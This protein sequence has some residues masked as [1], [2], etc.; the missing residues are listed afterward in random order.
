[1]QKMLFH[2]TGLNGQIEVYENRIV[3]RR[4]GAIAKLSQG[5]FK[6]DKEILLSKISAIQVK[7]GTIITNG[8]IQFSLSGGNEST[9]GLSEATRDENTVF[10]LKKYNNEVMKLKERIYSLLENNSPSE[11][12]NNASAADELLKLKKLL[13]EGILNEDEYQSEKSKIL[14]R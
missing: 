6:G 1:M 3:I 4:K 5:F 2:L 13:D 10:F 14:N 12:V 11:N 7:P 9:K 8:Y